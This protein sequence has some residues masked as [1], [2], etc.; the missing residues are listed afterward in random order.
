MN[1][2]AAE[3]N[4]HILWRFNF[5]L[6]RALEV[7]AKSLMGYGWG[8]RKGEVLLTLLQHHPHWTQMMNMLAHDL[9]W[10][11]K[12]ITKE[13]RAANLIKALIFGNHKG[14][15]T[16]LELLLKLASGDAKYG[17]VLPLPLG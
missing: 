6:G 9:Q 5:N 16:Q 12:P 3:S 14:A 10:P 7:Q 11:T 2:E 1:R 15:M 17:Y 13:D 8:F 4:F